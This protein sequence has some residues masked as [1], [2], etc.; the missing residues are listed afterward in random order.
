MIYKENELPN[1][2]KVVFNSYLEYDEETKDV[3]IKYNI[4]YDTGE[5]FAVPTDES[6]VRFAISMTDSIDDANKDM[7]HISERKGYAVSSPKSGFRV[8]D[9]RMRKVFVKSLYS[10]ALLLDYPTFFQMGED[11]I[12][13]NDLEFDNKDI[14][15]K[16]KNK[17]AEM[18]E[19][20]E[21]H[22][23]SK[24]LVPVQT[25]ETDVRHR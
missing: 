24:E 15:R 10:V 25:E 1:S 11:Y 14:Y 8:D 16:V 9:P 3:N 20:I 6:S 17:Q 19:F 4:F 7:V 22:I 21:S 5:G 2:K 12:Y 13:V 23:P 18:D